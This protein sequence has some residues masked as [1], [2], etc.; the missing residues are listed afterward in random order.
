[1]HTISPSSLTEEEGYWK[2]CLTA[3][4][5]MLAIVLLLMLWEYFVH[6]LHKHTPKSILP[7][8]EYS[9]SE[10]GGLGF[11]GLLLEISRVHEWVGEEHG[12]LLELF[13]FLHIAFFKVAIGYLSG[14]P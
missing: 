8:V 2:S 4:L 9:L 13:Q 14:Q 6:A 10:I 1:M 12:G 3:A 7:A 5:L 11:I